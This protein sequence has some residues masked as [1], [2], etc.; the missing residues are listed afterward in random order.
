MSWLDLASTATVAGELRNSVM[1]WS[2]EE[3]S[4]DSRQGE[5]YFLLSTVSTLSLELI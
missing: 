2:T 3:L 4:L 1:G 5:E